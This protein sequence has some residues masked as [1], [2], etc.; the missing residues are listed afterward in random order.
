[1]DISL[2]TLLDLVGTF[3]FAISGALA[4]SYKRLDIFGVLV[5]AFVTAL[6]GGTL[7]DLLMGQQP[8]GWM[9][10]TEYLLIVLFGAVFAYLFRRTLESLRRTL[11]VFDA[12]G[13]AVFTILGM[14]KALGLGLSPVIAIMMGILSAVFGGVIRDILCNEI[15]LI[16]RQEIYATACLAGGILYW[17]LEKYLPSLYLVPITILF[18]LILRVVAVRY[19]L[20]LPTFK[21]EQ[22][23]I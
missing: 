3:A 15:P 6:G 20:H 22:E 1:M 4:A 11:F 9:L 10:N 19:H 13:L 2:I 8:V 21:G 23:S 14:E 16:F 18:I 7:R 5:V 12:M 17:G